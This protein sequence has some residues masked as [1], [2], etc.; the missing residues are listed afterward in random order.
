MGLKH[1]IQLGG[2]FL[3]SLAMT[4][5]AHVASDAYYGRH[6]SESGLALAR[7]ISSQADLLSLQ[8]RERGGTADPLGWAVSALSQG[9]EPRVAK[10][11]KLEAGTAT[12]S[13]ESYRYERDTGIFDYS[14]ILAPERGQGVRIQLQV[15][16]LGFLGSH[17][18][19]GSDLLAVGVFGLIYLFLFF[20]TIWSFGLA[21]ERRLKALISRW[22]DQAKIVL[23][24]FGTHIR[25]LLRGEKVLITSAAECRDLLG[26][27]EGRLRLEV[28][29]LKRLRGQLEK[30]SQLGRQADTLALSA[31]IE[32]ARFGSPGKRLAEIIAELHRL[33]QEQKAEDQRA[34]PL[35]ESIAARTEGAAN[36]VYTA[37]QIANR[38]CG[39]TMEINAH[40]RDTT[41][42]VL[43]Q[44]KL[45]KELNEQ[46]G[47]LGAEYWRSLGLKTKLGSRGESGSGSG[48]GSGSDER[49]G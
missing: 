26:D 29:E 13:T 4:W 37:G 10:V 19:V 3:V 45:M 44:A 47:E 25:E 39:A 42:V 6:R 22:V 21:G 1:G 48:S 31:A 36:D 43:T 23:T 11:Y 2:C 8:A 12:A 16:Y 7:Q 35:A 27:L 40:V 17:S 15:G 28:S 38:L 49:S 41:A 34:T 14:K 18:Q 33:M 32:V 5:A 46:L 24:Q 9:A 30:M 20:L